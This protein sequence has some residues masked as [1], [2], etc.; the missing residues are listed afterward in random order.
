MTIF[1]KKEYHFY[2]LQIAYSLIEN[3]VEVEKDYLRINNL[4]Q[5]FLFFNI[6]TDI[7][8]RM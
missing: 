8:I 4:K 2:N 7:K 6:L 1:K 3:Q 5:F